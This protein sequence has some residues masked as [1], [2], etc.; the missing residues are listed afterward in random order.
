ML[1]IDDDRNTPT[2]P[3][4]YRAGE[5]GSL[6]GASTE[7]T[8]DSD[9]LMFS[10]SGSIHTMSTLQSTEVADYFRSVF[11]YTFPTDENVPLLFP[12]D[13]TADRLDVIMHLIVRLCRDG[14]NV[15]APVDEM[16]RKGGVDG[17][18]TGARVLDMVT[19]SGTWVGE[20]ASIYSTPK[21]IS[22]DTKPL[23][24]H[25]P[26]ARISYQVYNFYA[27]I[28]EQDATFDLVHLRQGVYAVSRPAPRVKPQIQTPQV[29]NCDSVTLQTKDF[30][31][32]LRE[33]HR[34]LKPNGFL[35]ITELPIQTY[36]GN[37]PVPFHSGAHMAQGIEFVLDAC[38][39]EGADT[40]AWQDMN[41]RL[42]PSHQLWGNVKPNAL[43][44]HPSPNKETYGTRPVRG[45]HSIHL[46]KVPVSFG[47]W[48]SDEH[49]KV[50]GGLI[51]L[52]S[53]HH[54]ASLLPV[55]VLRGVDEDQA[56]R[57]VEKLLQEITD[58][59]KYRA[60]LILHMWSARKL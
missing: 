22:L 41:A 33:L 57:F 25:K 50:I 1:P 37:P 15:P 52:W 16:L 47:A 40:T 44:Q 5:A 17:R 51:R 18:G 23:V 59:D 38:K 6:S 54:S 13:T 39:A 46:H 21:F 32:L 42:E 11:G 3:I 43:G 34:V 60:H 7:H 12:T 36:E 58:A 31:S 48:P 24:P 30:N 4:V 56:K 27:G 10:D 55:I 8:S 49:Q 2:D 9:G 26:H 20:M 14:M 35:L 53:F 45:F 28:M 29:L 19:N